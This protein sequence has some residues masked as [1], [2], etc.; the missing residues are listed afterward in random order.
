MSRPRPRTGTG[1]LLR[2]SLAVAGLALGAIAGGCSDH[3]SPPPAPSP[4]TFWLAPNGSEVVLKLVDSP[5]TVP[6]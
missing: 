1:A 5:P 3:A 2:A 4:G 6:F